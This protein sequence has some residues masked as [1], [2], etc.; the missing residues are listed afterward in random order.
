[1]SL[2]SFMV[3]RQVL[4]PRTDLGGHLDGADDAEELVLYRL[5]GY[6]SPGMPAVTDPA[7][8]GVEVL[9]L[10]ALNGHGVSAVTA[11]DQPT[12]EV[13]I[14][15]PIGGPIVSGEGRL[16]LV[17]HLLRDDRRM[18]AR[19]S[20]TAPRDLADVEPVLE[21]PLEVGAREAWRLVGEIDPTVEEC[22]AEG[23]KGELA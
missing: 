19:V 15:V 16:H 14:S 7:A 8:A 21:H 13:N 17:E 2:G 12:T 3:P 18:M 22:L 10:D 23:G 9:P 6:S 5:A 1:M 11:S 20:G 4:E